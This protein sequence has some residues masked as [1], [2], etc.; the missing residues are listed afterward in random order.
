MVDL[1]RKILIF[2]DQPHTQLLERL[3][4]VLS[5]DQKEIRLKITDKSQKHG[6]K[7]KN[8]VVR[9]YPAV[10]FCT[11]GLRIDVQ[12]ATRFFL[13]SPEVNQE[14]IR[15]AILEKI[16]KETDNA[17]YKHW[18]EDLPERKA[19]KERILGIKEAGVQEIRIADSSS[20]VDRFMASNKILKPRHQRDIGRLL[21]LVKSFALLNLWWREQ[22][23]ST[24]TA[25]QEDIEA[26]FE[27]WDKISVS[28]EM[29]LPPYIFKLYQ[30]VILVAWE[31]RKK[32]FPDSMKDHGLSR[33]DILQKHYAV[34]GRMLDNN[35]LRQQ[36]L[37][38]L[39][40]AGLITQEQHATDKRK[41]LV[42][43]TV[44]GTISEI[45][46]NSEMEGGVKEFDIEELAE[47]IPF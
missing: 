47:Q 11:A 4:P 30:E 9:G 45:L 24:I 23:G 12:E 21:A 3:R 34:Y 29:N 5:H 36:I 38:M 32:E 8:V 16:K 25:N 10:I 20:I 39:E 22:D 40:T 44:D 7:T 18:L 6:L 19:L 13:L 28:Q 14:K 1:S 2:L 41:I 46:N 37:P 42:Y 35:Q 27:V 15:Q 43:P 31:E 17:S 33:Q 26:A